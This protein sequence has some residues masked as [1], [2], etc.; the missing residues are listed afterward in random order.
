MLPDIIK[1]KLS[2]LK[3]DLLS[4]PNTQFGHRIKIYVLLLRNMRYEKV[5]LSSDLQKHPHELLEV[6][7]DE[8]IV[9]LKAFQDILFIEGNVQS[10]IFKEHDNKNWPAIHEY[11]F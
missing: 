11:V 1:N 7:V 10:K 8:A 3:Q 6:I 2:Q 9:T 4:L 5:H